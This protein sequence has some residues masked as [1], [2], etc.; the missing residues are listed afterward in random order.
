[1]FLAHRSQAQALLVGTA[2]QHCGGAVDTRQLQSGIGE[3]DAGTR[4]TFSFLFTPGSQLTGR[5]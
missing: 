2:W 5:F 1:M 3:M 4:L